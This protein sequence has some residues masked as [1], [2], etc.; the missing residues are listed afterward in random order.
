ME[1]NDISCLSCGHCFYDHA[2]RFTEE[3][4]AKLKR[5]VGCRIIGCGC[6]KF[7]GQAAAGGTSPDFNGWDCY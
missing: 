2:G 6:G 4:Q 1:P 3:E 5:E 7:V